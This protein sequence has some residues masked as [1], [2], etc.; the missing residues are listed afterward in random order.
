[1]KRHCDELGGDLVRPA[2][3]KCVRR[4]SAELFER[5][6]SSGMAQVRRFSE[7]VTR[8]LTLEQFYGAAPS[9][10]ACHRG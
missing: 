2:P 1:M 3:P 5:H 9:G 8:S 4:P 10:T 7:A 6:H